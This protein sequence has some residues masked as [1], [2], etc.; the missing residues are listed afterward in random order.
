MTQPFNQSVHDG[1]LSLGFTWERMPES[2]EDHGG[3][4]SGPMIDYVPACDVYS[5]DDEHIFIDPNG[6]SYCDDEE[7]PL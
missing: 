3:P 7:I 6:I 2:S 5:I 1:L 4:E